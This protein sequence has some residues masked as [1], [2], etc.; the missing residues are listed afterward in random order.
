[1]QSNLFCQTQPPTSWKACH[2][3]AFDGDLE[4]IKEIAA[5]EARALH[6]ADENGWQV[7]FCYSY[8]CVSFAVSSMSGSYLILFILKANTFGDFGQQ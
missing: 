3:A 2:K 4:K 5:N 6:Y 1:M 7:R 8:N